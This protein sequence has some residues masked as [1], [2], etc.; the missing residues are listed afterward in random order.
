MGKRSVF[1]ATSLDG[2]IARE[3]G[4]IDWLIA[5]NASVPPGE[6]CGYAA[7]MSGVDALVMGR[8]TF[9]LVRTFDAWPYGEKPVVVLSG[10][11]TALPEDVP[12]SVML[13]SG[14]PEEVVERLASRGLFNLYIDGGITIQRFLA[15]GLIDEL[16]ITT[17][18]IL[19]GKGRP[20]FGPLEQDIRLELASS[21]AYDFGF[22][23]NRYRVR[24]PG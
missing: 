7:F 9:E 13:A 1:I 10:S 22:V 18:P 15:A 20:L 8:N 3:D 12:P 23:Q 2:Y 24:K 5:A 17:I 6:D 14:K 19:L 21:R 4:S 16:T 11:L